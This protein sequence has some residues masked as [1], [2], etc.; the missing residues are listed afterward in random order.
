MTRAS[1]SDF[2]RGW[3]YSTPWPRTALVLVGFPSSALAPLDRPLARRHVSAFV[4]CL[5]IVWAVAV[6]A[7]VLI[8][9][10]I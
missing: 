4:V 5:L 6:L 7:V 9:R 10:T 8:R 3:L 1:H 2:C